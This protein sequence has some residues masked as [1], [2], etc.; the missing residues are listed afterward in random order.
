MDTYTCNIGHPNCSTEYEGGK[1]AVETVSRYDCVTKG[2]WDGYGVME[3]D[4]RFGE[5]V[6]YDDYVALQKKWE[7][8]CSND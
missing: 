1:C 6:N 4:D 3:R 5:W 2:E 7:A 8:I